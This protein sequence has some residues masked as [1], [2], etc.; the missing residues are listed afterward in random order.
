M[1][2]IEV[3]NSWL[4]FINMNKKNYD[5]DLYKVFKLSNNFMVAMATCLPPHMSLSVPVC[6]HRSSTDKGR[7]EIIN[8]KSVKPGETRNTSEQNIMY[9][10]VTS[11]LFL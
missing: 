4:L 1:T 7:N 2:C 5:E 10:C 9:H 11:V 3:N 8:T 6:V